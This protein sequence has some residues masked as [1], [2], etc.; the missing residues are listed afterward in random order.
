MRG[1][2]KGHGNTEM[3]IVSSTGGGAGDGVLAWWGRTAATKGPQHFRF[4]VY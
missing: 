2:Q 3:E 1:D 4:P